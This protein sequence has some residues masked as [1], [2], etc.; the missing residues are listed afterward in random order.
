MFNKKLGKIAIKE[1]L[2]NLPDGI[3]FADNN[4][5]IIFANKIMYDLY[6][7]L[8]NSV[9]QSIYSLWQAVLDEQKTNDKAE[10]INDNS[11]LMH[12]NDKT[13]QFN[14]SELKIHEKTFLVIKAIDI[15]T[16][17]S[18]QKELIIKNAELRTL[19]E[20]I[21]ATK[22]TIEKGVYEN[23]TTNAKIRIH[24]TMGTNLTRIKRYLATGE[25]NINEFLDIWK[26]S[27][28]IFS[29]DLNTKKEYSFNSLTEAAQAIGV[30]LKI[31]GSAPKSEKLFEVIVV[32]VRECLINAVIHADATEMYL[33]ISNDDLKYNIEIM[34][35][36]KKAKAKIIEGGGIKT[37][38]NYAEKLNGT[39]SYSLE[40]NFVIYIEIPKIFI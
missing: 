20:Q 37:I 15:S 31:R 24:S 13:Y 5:I 28:Q 26:E 17:Y 35:N 6:Y 10:F 19:Q 39:F 21:I 38:R 25:G 34:N 29:K 33:T 32:V 12:F 2:D 7:E 4:G 40:P 27:Y 36:G 1:G 3:C 14:F 8:T 22:N 18:L 16:I 23:E 9:L 30:D 11:P